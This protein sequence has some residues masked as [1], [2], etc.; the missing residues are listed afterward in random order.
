VK[1]GGNRPN[2][3]KNGEP[4]ADTQA[5]QELVQKGIVI[6]RPGSGTF[7]RL[8]IADQ[9]S[10]S[11]LFGLLIPDL[12]ETEIYEPICQ[13]AR[14]WGQRAA[15]SCAKLLTSLRLSESPLVSNCPSSAILQFLVFS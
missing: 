10:T 5:F 14:Q 9:P 7:V 15:G 12:G 11:R 2:E 13:G 1:R 8:D 3:N 6:R 4:A